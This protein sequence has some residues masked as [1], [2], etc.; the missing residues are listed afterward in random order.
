[1]TTRS[2]YARA[3]LTRSD[4]LGDLRRFLHDLKGALRRAARRAGVP[5]RVHPDAWAPGLGYH[6][7]CGRRLFRRPSSCS[8]SGIPG[9]VSN[10]SGLRSVSSSDER[11]RGAAPAADHFRRVRGRANGWN[12][13]R[14]PVGAGDGCT[15]PALSPDR[16]RTRPKRDCRRGDRSRCAMKT[17]LPLL[18]F[19]ALP[20][21]AHVMSMST[22]DISIDGARAHY[23]LSMPVYEI[24]HVSN[25]DTS[26]FEHIRFS[27][28]G[29]TGRILKKSCHE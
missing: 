7:C 18:A 11:R 12:S 4:C 23:E 16:A 5:P 20:L 10:L 25:P 8:D 24:A 14:L 21:S 9:C 13:R 3:R 29:E 28:A 26:L 6:H 17:L 22:G 27:S 19:A 15:A 2:I 1:R